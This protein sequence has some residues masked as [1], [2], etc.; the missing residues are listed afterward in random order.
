MKYLKKFNEE[1][2]PSTYRTAA[3]KLSK[4]GHK[5]R[6]SNLEDWANHVETENIT[7]EKEEKRRFLSQFGKFKMDVLIKGVPRMTGDFYIQI[8]GLD[9]Y[10][11]TDVYHDI[12]NDDGTINYGEHVMWFE[13]GFMP[14]D[15]D[16]ELDFYDLKEDGFLENDNFYSGLY[17]CMS[18]GL[19]IIRNNEKEINPN[20]NYYYENSRDNVEFKFHDRKEAIRF[21]KLL[22]DAFLGNN[23]WGE[24]KETL[25]DSILS[26]FLNKTR[27]SKLPEDVFNEESYQKIANSIKTLSLNK[28]YSE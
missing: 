26:V 18:F 25:K 3:D 11:F 13:L 19:T 27:Y 24:S 5:R 20:G 14:T 28:L 22:S 6:S 17:W 16:C 7:K 4:I 8:G 10:N 12:V 15:E 23:K 21:R 1:L 2:R 9:H